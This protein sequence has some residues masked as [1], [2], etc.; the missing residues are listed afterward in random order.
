MVSS[1]KLLWLWKATFS[2]LALAMAQVPTPDVGRLLSGDGVPRRTFVNA[3]LEHKLDV[4]LPLT[5][6]EEKIA[7]YGDGVLTIHQQAV[8]LEYGIL[9]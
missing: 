8:G 9:H 4:G 7:N 6:Y 5:E 1:F 2:T 3:E